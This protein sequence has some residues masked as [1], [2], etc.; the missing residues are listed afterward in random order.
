M[1]FC[2]FNAILTKTTTGV[3]IK[4]GKWILKMKEPRAGIIKMFLKNDEEERA[5]SES[6]SKM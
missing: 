6:K 1:M 3:F 4:F 5:L 2:M